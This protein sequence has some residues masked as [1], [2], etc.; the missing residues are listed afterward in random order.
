[1]SVKIK[2]WHGFTLVRNRRRITSVTTPDGE[3]FENPRYVRFSAVYLPRASLWIFLLVG[4][5]L[6]AGVAYLINKQNHID[7]FWKTTYAKVVANE[8]V[9]YKSRKQRSASSNRKQGFRPVF[10]FT[11]EDGKPHTYKGSIRSEQCRLELTEQIRFNPSDPN[12]FVRA[13]EPSRL[14][15]AGLLGVFGAASI[16][17]S[18]VVAILGPFD[19]VFVQVNDR[20]WMFRRGQYGR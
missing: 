7:R 6:F 8:S 9:E 12:D 4:F 5:T 1:M 17:M 10:E 14:I 15:G 3:V 19:K 16:V 18:L 2:I 13:S 11:T 20:T